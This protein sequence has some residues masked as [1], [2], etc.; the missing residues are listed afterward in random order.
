MKKYLITG[1]TAALAMTSTM[2]PADT[3]SEGANS[4]YLGIAMT[5]T[6]LEDDNTAVKLGY[7]RKLGIL[8]GLSV[9]FELSKSIFD[10]SSKDDT[11]VQIAPETNESPTPRN[12]I[13]YVSFGTLAR[14]DYSLDSLVS[15]TGLY[16][17]VG[18]AYK[19]IEYAGSSDRTFDLTYGGGVT[20]ALTPGLSA[21]VDYT[22]L[23]GDI[24]L[25]EAS[26][27][28]KASF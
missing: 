24:E 17:R 3:H 27:G 9:D 15:G 23:D 11:D 16:G 21:F 18:G 26:I 8:P 28:I 13:S 5:D 12:E 10:E 1:M 6:M 22:H 7:N 14:Y 19:D 20:Y 2:S 25:K 4:V